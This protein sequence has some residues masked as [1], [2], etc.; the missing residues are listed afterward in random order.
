MKGTI[1][2]RFDKQHSQSTSHDSI[3]TFYDDISILSDIYIVHVLLRRMLFIVASAM[4]SVYTDLNELTGNKL[5]DHSAEFELVL[6]SLLTQFILFRNSMVFY[7]DRGQ[8]SMNVHQK[9]VYSNAIFD[10]I[11]AFRYLFNDNLIPS[12][13]SSHINDLKGLLNLSDI[14]LLKTDNDLSDRVDEAKDILGNN[15][16]EEMIKVNTVFIHLIEVKI[17]K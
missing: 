2:N 3:S 10:A 12:N 11:K 8:N 6:R 16:N 4:Q 9:N 15:L 7:N 14:M 13:I 5:K 1:K 17:G